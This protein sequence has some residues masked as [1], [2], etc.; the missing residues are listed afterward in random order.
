MSGN[1]IERIQYLNPA[2]MRSYEVQPRIEYSIVGR[3]SGKTTG[4]QAPRL[5]M[6]AEK[7][8]RGMIG[9]V[10]A[11]YMQLLTRVLPGIVKGWRELG[12]VE[13]RDFWVGQFAPKNYGIYKPFKSPLKTEYLIHTKHG[14]AISLFSQDKPGMSNGV[15]IVAFSCDEAKFINKTRLDEEIKPAMRGEEHLF[16]KLGCYHAELY[17]SDMPNHHSGMWLLE[18][19]P[20]DDATIELIIKTQR[21]IWE[22]DATLTQYENSY[23]EKLISQRNTLERMLEQ[24]RARCVMVNKASSLQNLHVLGVKWL[25]HMMDTL[26]EHELKSSILGLRVTKGVTSFY[27]ELDLVKH[28]YHPTPSSY[29]MSI[30]YNW[31]KIADR[32]FRCDMEFDW[33]IDTLHVSIDSGGT[34]N[35][36]VVGCKRIQ[37]INCINTFYRHHPGKIKDVV[38]DFKKYFLHKP[39]KKIVFHF[40]QTAVATRAETEYSVRDIVVNTLEDHEY[41]RWYVEQNY[42]R[43]TPSY[44]W[45]FDTIAALCKGEHPSGF[46][47]AFNILNFEKV[48]ESCIAAN[49]IQNGNKIEKDKSSEKRDGQGK[50]KVSQ[51]KAT[52]LSEAFDLMVSGMVRY[53]HTSTLAT[54]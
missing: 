6:W 5:K 15:D 54:Y 32:D 53:Y 31:D 7:M 22:I 1:K 44:Q 11:S 49:V 27:H 13:G 26:P 43:Q 52:H 25:E 50:F 30:G 9:L 23:A 21:R 37:K 33:D 29:L 45:R 42:L 14:S 12:W 35:C 40:D 28:G 8:P 20:S 10:G 48:Y 16:G 36:L 47:I 4:I 19:A 38:V 34:F 51:E 46:T 2:Q 3:G 17:T 18:K 41:G 39:V 24:L